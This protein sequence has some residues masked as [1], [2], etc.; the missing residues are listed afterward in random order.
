MAATAGCSV[1]NGSSGNSDSSANSGNVEQSNI[2]LGLMPGVDF[3]PAFIA[4]KKGYFKDEG[5]N[6]KYTMFQGGIQSFPA[7]M[8]GSVQF[9]FGNWPTFFQAQQKVDASGH[10]DQG[11]RLVANA[12]QAGQDSFDV[13]A[14]PGSG[15]NSVRDLAN[16]K[17]AINGLGNIN[18]LLMDATLDD[19]AINH[20]SIQ[21]VNMGFPQMPQALASHEVDAAISIE[22]FLTQAERQLGAKP[23]ARLSS[24]QTNQMPISGYATT[25][26]FAAKSPKT[27]AAFQRALQRGQKDAADP[28]TVRQILPGFIPNIDAGTAALIQLGTYPTTVSA[29]QLQRVVD[30][31]VS[32]KL[33]PGPLNVQQMI[34]P[35]PST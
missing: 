23:I 29:T 11:V 34:Q 25:D 2:T 7:L 15:I 24:G 5:L 22:P 20:D 19:N 12:Y 35:Q 30:L 32:Y 18:E 6:V 14:M 10:P 27:V 17:V 28:Q 8:S 21:Y 33:L 3:A 31:M 16:K 13:L 26:A 9:T 1:L 4:L